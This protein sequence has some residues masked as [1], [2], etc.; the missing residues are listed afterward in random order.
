MKYILKYC[1]VSVSPENMEHLFGFS[2]VKEMNKRQESIFYMEVNPLL[3]SI[4]KFKSAVCKH[5]IVTTIYHKVDQYP[6]AT[7]TH[8][9]FL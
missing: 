4:G 8:Q 9:L 2:C 3:K 6:N 5:G 7:F 1:K